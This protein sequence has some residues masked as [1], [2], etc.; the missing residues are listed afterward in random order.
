MRRALA[1]FV[2]VLVVACSAQTTGQNSS[3]ASVTK[4]RSALEELR[5]TPEDPTVQ[6][7]YLEAFPRT[8]KEYLQLFDLDQPLSEEVVEYVDSLSS[9][10]T[11][12]EERV[13][14]LLVTLSKDAHYDADAPAYLQHTTCGF[15]GE[16]T[17]TFLTFLGRLPPVKQA[18]L[19][20][21]LAD[22]ENHRAYPEYQV[23][24]DHLRTLGEVTF[25]SKFERARAEREK[26]PHD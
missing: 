1:L 18:N 22:V 14:N 26:R 12:H 4:L 20:T 9:L 8:Y 11:N 10:A 15:A 5:K 24:I 19:I 7:R 21:F 23:V 25:A 17:K 6:R 3:S 2:C 13:G 16:H